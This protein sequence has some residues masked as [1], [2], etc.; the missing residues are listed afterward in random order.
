MLLQKAMEALGS[1]F[2]ILQSTP[3][4]FLMALL[5]Y[6]QGGSNLLISRAIN[7]PSAFPMKHSAL[8]FRIP[9][10]MPNFYLGF[11][12]F[13][14]SVQTMGQILDS[15]VG[16]FPCSHSNGGPVTTL[17]TSGQDAFCMFT[18]HGRIGDASLSTYQHHCV[19]DGPDRFLVSCHCV[20][21]GD[22]CFAHFQLHDF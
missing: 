22:F 6:L 18:N 3:I 21:C 19:L 4:T 13:M 5:S 11:I 20:L 16:F 1:P 2:V 12:L 17:L 7:T 8:L 9:S 14:G 10:Q 15:C